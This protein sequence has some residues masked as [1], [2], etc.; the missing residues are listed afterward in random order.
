MN[1]GVRI[2]PA[3]TTATQAPQSSVQNVPAGDSFA[4][5]LTAASA[6][7]P[8]NQPAAGSRQGMAGRSTTKQ[9]E[10]K[11]SSNQ[12]KHTAIVQSPVPHDP[13]NTESAALIP[14]PIQAAP[15]DTE[16]SPTQDNSQSANDGSSAI[17]EKAAGVDAPRLSNDLPGSQLTHSPSNTTG[18][19]SDA[20]LQ[21]PLTS[22]GL[23]DAADASHSTVPF[24]SI[25][26]P[27]LPAGS[28]ECAAGNALDPSMQL[29]IPAA[30]SNKQSGIAP[31]NTNTQKIA[32]DA[33]R[34]TN[35][36]L[37]GTPN[38]GA[39][40]TKDDSTGSGNLPNH[41][42]QNAQADSS[43]SAASTPGV[44]GIAA[45]HPQLQTV[46]NQV[47][48]H[49][50]AITPRGTDTLADATHLGARP[51]AT[52]SSESESNE[53]MAASGISDAK[54]MQTMSESEM[55]IGLSSSGFGDI[56]I[57]TSVSNHQLLAQISLDHNELSQ[58]ISA[59]VSSLQTKLGDEYG[60]HTSI[61]INNFASP[62]S[63][64]PGHSSQKERGTPFGI[65]QAADA[66][67]Q[68]EEVTGLSPEVF[69]STANGTRLDI[70]A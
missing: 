57:R 25:A 55:R 5:V 8:S 33:S 41:N 13:A 60:L 61:E 12:S 65:S 9:A 36:D 52:P 43:Q 22:A 68:R 63:G 31:A 20:S 44:Q 48:S 3:A 47:V 58:A 14:Q 1:I 35:P 23:L 56:S 27:G 30:G 54:L 40:K 66:A 7:P 34:S 45:A 46:M 11:A 49:E 42:S 2:S 18:Q 29:S 4:F 28:Y 67:A 26:L 21:D 64:E 10:G 59:H 19:E 37:I 16:Q 51:E 50:S 15:S 70:R 62:Y 32:S 17:S 24:E 69:V 6:K 38:S 53:A 39:G